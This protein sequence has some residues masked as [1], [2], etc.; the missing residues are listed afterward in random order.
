MPSVAQASPPSRTL[1]VA[2]EADEAAVAL[3][4]IQNRQVVRHLPGSVAEDEVVD[5]V[6]V[7][8]QVAPHA[9]GLVP[10]ADV[11]SERR[12]RVQLRVADLEGQ[13]SDVRAEVVELLERRRAV[14][15]AEVGDEGAVGAD[16][17]VQADGRRRPPELPVARVGRLEAVLLFLVLVVVL[18]LVLVVVVIVVVHVVVVVVRVVVS[19]FLHCVVV[20]P[21]DAFRGPVVVLLDAAAELQ[22]GRARSSTPRRRRPQ[23]KPG[24]SAAPGPRRPTASKSRSW[25]QAPNLPENRSVC[26]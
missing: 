3:D 14:R 10:E 24:R 17:G 2:S 15:V 20:M 19:L 7:G 9:A 21:P 25:V 26:C 11:E 22:P 13:V 4:E 6:D 18:F 1:P 5:G 12:L 8:V 23:R 16:V